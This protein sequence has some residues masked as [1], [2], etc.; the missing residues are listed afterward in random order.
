MLDISAQTLKFVW[1]L[2]SNPSEGTNYYISAL[3]LQE[4]KAAYDAKTSKLTV[5]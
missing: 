2:S 3:V 4:Q 5:D 1:D